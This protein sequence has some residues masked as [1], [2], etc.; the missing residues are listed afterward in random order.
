MAVH[1]RT[2]DEDAEANTA[3]S[4]DH[5]DDHAQ[6]SE[7]PEWA[8]SA[9]YPLKSAGLIGEAGTHRASAVLSVVNR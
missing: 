4:G 6:T 3:N 9:R 8:S 2:D 1:I 5:Q 7:W